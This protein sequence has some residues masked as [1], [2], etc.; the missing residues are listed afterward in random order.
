MLG[1]KVA[2]L[3]IIGVLILV[4]AC[5]KIEEP[6]GAGKEPAGWPSE[7][8]LAQPLSEEDFSGR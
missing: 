5:T 7:C 3:L 2:V 6:A 1:R 8:P 4:T